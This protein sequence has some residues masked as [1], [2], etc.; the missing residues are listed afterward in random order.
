[1][2]VLITVIFFE[3]SKNALKHLLIFHFY[4]LERNVDY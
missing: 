1:M 3:N 2:T 4:H